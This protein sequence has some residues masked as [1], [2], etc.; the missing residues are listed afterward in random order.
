MPPR[1]KFT[2]EE[3][4][5]AALA[6]VSE[7]GV[8]AL[9]AREL[10]KAMGCSTRPIFTLF[11][12]MEELKAEVRRL[13]SVQVEK[14][15]SHVMYETG[16]FDQS[17]MEAV[18]FAK[19][20]PNLYELVFMVGGGRQR[21]FLELLQ[22]TEVTERDYLD[23][24]QDTYGLE[25]Q[26]AALLFRHMWVYCLGMG[27]LC[28]TQ[29]YLFSEAELE[30]SVSRAFEA[31]LTHL[32]REAC[33]RECGEASSEVPLIGLKPPAGLDIGKG[34]RAVVNACANGKEGS[35]EVMEW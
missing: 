30:Q 8:G 33:L 32:R 5:L 25:G 1:P 7:Q 28:A 19:R 20:E 16:C 31:M 18:R 15:C 23:F 27:V 29:R 24:I 34:E 14:I 12:D 21:T 17:V 22:D 4:V 35:K 10:A 3:I 2:R 6:L 9:T 11:S 26:D 13:A